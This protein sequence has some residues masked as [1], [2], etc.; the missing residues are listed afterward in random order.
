MPHSVSSPALTSSG[1]FE[2]LFRDGT[3]L[4]T[5]FDA[6]VIDYLDANTPAGVQRPYDQAVLYNV[7][8]TLEDMQHSN[9]TVTFPPEDSSSIPE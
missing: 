2:D 3:Y 6:K 4:I 8:I 5:F 7:Y 1:C 9:W